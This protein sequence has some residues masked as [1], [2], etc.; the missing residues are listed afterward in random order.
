MDKK[1]YN[2]ETDNDVVKQELRKYLK[3]EKIY[4]E[5]SGID[6]KFVHFE[7]KCSKI[8]LD[9]INRLLDFLYLF[10]NVEQ[11]D[12]YTEIACTIAETVCEMKEKGYS[13]V[14]I[15]TEKK[16]MAAIAMKLY[17]FNPELLE[18]LEK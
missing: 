17:K 16:S 8:E 3:M 13:N 18:Y 5:A 6:R 7:V 12:K 10:D 14:A 15:D 2:L 4:Y 1:W 11:F 9:D